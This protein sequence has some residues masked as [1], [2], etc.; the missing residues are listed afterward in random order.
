MFPIALNSTPVSYAGSDILR[1]TVSFNYD[2]YVAGKVSSLDYARKSDNNRIFDGLNGLSN[3]L[4]TLN[5]DREDLI[6]R[7]QIASGQTKLIGNDSIV[8][9]LDKNGNEVGPV[10]S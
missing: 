7:Q 6:R 1:A 4:S 10:R 8:R 2:R 5:S 3:I 9:N